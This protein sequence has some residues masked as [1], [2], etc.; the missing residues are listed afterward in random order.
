MNKRKRNKEIK[1]RQSLS[2]KYLGFAAAAGNVQLFRAL[3]HRSRGKQSLYYG[4][5]VDTFKHAVRVNDV[6]ML[7]FLFEQ[8]ATTTNSTQL[9]LNAQLGWDLFDL[10]LNNDLK[11]A[12][13][14]NNSLTPLIRFL[15]HRFP[16]MAPTYQQLNNVATA[17]DIALFEYLTTKFPNLEPGY[18]TL[19]NAAE[20]G[21]YRLFS[22]VADK[23]APGTLR[24]V[25]ENILNKATE[26]GSI[27]LVKH[28]VEER[29]VLPSSSTMETLRHFRARTTKVFKYLSKVYNFFSDFYNWRNNNGADG[30]GLG[31]RLDGGVSLEGN[32]FAI[33]RQRMNR[34]RVDI[35][36]D[37]GD[38]FK[39]K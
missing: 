7:E 30:W 36:D 32:P 29:H 11:P 14:S 8:C 39:L 26:R 17:G 15:L 16:H 35:G 10:A 24:L 12:Q 2:N 5:H 37:D 20:S 23:S 18:D 3:V 1:E 19:A 9:Q 33:L 27:D 4:L 13:Y 28:I 38:I 22:A 6:H 31:H 21:D 25:D 34:E